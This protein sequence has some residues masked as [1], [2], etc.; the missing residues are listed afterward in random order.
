MNLLCQSRESSEG[1]LKSKRATRW[2][3]GSAG[4]DLYGWQAEMRSGSHK[5]SRGLLGSGDGASVVSHSKVF[6]CKMAKRLYI[7]IQ[8]YTP[9][10]PYHK[11]VFINGV[12]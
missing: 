4:L 12:S 7:L 6:K 1:R 9:A 5:F 10:F 3:R 8:I 11:Y 2:G